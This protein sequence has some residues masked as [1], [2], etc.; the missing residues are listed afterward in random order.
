M[1]ITAISGAGHLQVF[2]SQQHATRRRVRSVSSL[3][4]CINVPTSPNRNPKGSAVSHSN[5]QDNLVC[6]ALHRTSRRSTR[7]SDYV[8]HGP[9]TFCNQLIAASQASSLSSD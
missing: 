1:S 5:V 6:Q 9:K 8:T 2:R 3:C 4:L 7:P